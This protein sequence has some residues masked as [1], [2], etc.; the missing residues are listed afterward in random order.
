[1]DNYQNFI[2]L[3]T[4]AR[5]LEK[6]GRRETW[7]EAV[8]RYKN[9]FLP[10][11][12]EEGVPEFLEAV[13]EIRA[14]EI[15]PS[16]RA[17]WAAGPALEREN[18]AAYNCSYLAIDNIKSFAECL[19]LLLCGCGVG[20]SV[21]QKHIDKLP[22]VPT[23]FENGSH[24]IV[25]ADSKQGW[26]E[27][28]YHLIKGLYAGYTHTLDYS[29][30]RA[31][32]MPLKTFGGRASGPEPLKNLCNS[33]I[34]MFEAAKGRKLISTECSDICCMIADSVIVGGVRRS[35]EVMLSDVN[36]EKMRFAKSG[37]WWEKH[38]YRANMN[39]SSIYE[40]KPSADIFMEE[41]LA[42]MRSGSG[43]RGIINRQ[44][45]KASRKGLRNSDSA[46]VNPCCLTG[47]SIVSTPEGEINLN[48][49]VKKHEA[50]SI[51]NVISYNVNAK[52]CEEGEV[53]MASLTR[54][55][56]NII[57]IKAKDGSFIKVTPDHKVFVVDKGW[58]EASQIKSGDKILKLK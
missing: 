52:T 44:A 17:L 48:D 7:D 50:G 49:L 1:M 11:I 31:K 27:G 36:D 53:S 55:K 20:I 40:Y 2:R 23:A 5:Y 37:N 18:L 26:A 4:Y 22:I 16:M 28:L 8:D 19:Y 42:L 13:E 29:K 38:P 24:S 10:R 15:V 9:F 35:S 47:D 41:W 25:F 6:E 56:A 34:R 33:V 21:E 12:P 3:R 54:K 43:E 45:L 51:N 46:G 58:I 57:K 30:I 39:I 14:G 32:G